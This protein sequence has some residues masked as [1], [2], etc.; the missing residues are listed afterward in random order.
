MSAKFTQ[1]KI[2]GFP[3]INKVFLIVLAVFSLSGCSSMKQSDSD[4]AAPAKPPAQ[5]TMK[6]AAQSPQVVALKDGDSY[7]LNID[8]V[9]QIIDG[10][11]YQMMAYNGSIPGPIIKVRQNDEITVNLKNNSNIPTS[12]HSHGVRVE[13]AFDGVVDILQKPIGNGET[14]SYKLKFPD[15]GM[16]WYHPHLN[17]VFTQSHG[18]YGNYWVIPKDENYWPPVNVEVPLMVTDISIKNGQAGQY[19]KVSDHAL[20][21]KFGNLFLTN[22]ETEFRKTFRQGEVVR[23]YFT[24]AANTRVFN[25]TIPQARMKLVG[26]DNGRYQR[27]TWVEN[28]VLSPSERAII[29]VMFEKPGLYSLQSTNTQNTYDLAKFDVL[30][31]KVDDDLSDDFLKLRENSEWNDWMDKIEPDF[32]RKA[33]HRIRFDL[34]MP[35]MGRMSMMNS[36]DTS[37]QDHGMMGHGMMNEMNQS[38]QGANEL[39]DNL[40]WQNKIEWE[41]TMSMMNAMSLTNSTKWKIVD[42]D[43]G[44]ENMD[45][46]WKFK[47]GDLVKIEVFNDPRSAHPMQHPLHFHGQRILLL[48]NNGV[49]NDNLVWKDTVLIPKGDRVEILVE[50]SNPGQWMAHCHISEH[51]ESGMMLQFTVE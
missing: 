16:F 20:M 51:L 43:S 44:A 17:E 39:T 14:F 11:T 47:Q 7:D 13:N 30:G 3:F 8:L 36:Q 21:G 37:A 31:K 24:N 6:Q 42:E 26:G 12:L 29:D 38:N 5:S 23:F 46:N 27:E 35:M 4:L 18:L 34:A 49:K 48:S 33:D 32:D 15:A 25:L 45:I 22:G 10:Q 1:E 28:V 19:S 50:M 41:D 9:D 40:A 2:T